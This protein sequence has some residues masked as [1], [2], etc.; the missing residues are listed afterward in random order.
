MKTD[1]P[2]GKGVEAASSALNTGKPNAKCA[3]SCVIAT[4]QKVLDRRL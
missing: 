1:T 2:G 3:A 4:G